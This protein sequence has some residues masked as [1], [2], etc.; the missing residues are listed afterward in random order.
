MDSWS[1]D[2]ELGRH[3]DKIN[4]VLMPP[5]GI[6]AISDNLEDDEDIS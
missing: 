2:D 4:I 6:D 3:A 1:D 5:D